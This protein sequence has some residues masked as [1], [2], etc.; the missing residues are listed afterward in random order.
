METVRRLAA[1]GQ[2][3]GEKQE[4]GGSAGGEAALI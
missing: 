2:G 3:A 1:R 4:H